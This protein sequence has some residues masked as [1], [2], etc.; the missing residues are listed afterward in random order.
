MLKDLLEFKNKI[1]APVPAHPFS[2]NVR[3][4]EVKRVNPSSI[5]MSYSYVK[6]Y[7]IPLNKIPNLYGINENITPVTPEPQPDPIKF[8]PLTLYDIKP[9]KGFMTQVSESY[10]KKPFIERMANQMQLDAGGGTNSLAVVSSIAGGKDLQTILNGMNKSK[11]PATTTTSTIGAPINTAPKSELTPQITPTPTPAPH[12]TPETKSPSSTITMSSV[13]DAFGNVLSTTGEAFRSAKA[14]LSEAFN[15][16]T[17][18]KTNEE[19]NQ[20]EEVIDIV[21]VFNSDDEINAFNEYQEITGKMIYITQFRNEVEA[22][23]EKQDNPNWWRGKRILKL[24]IENAKA[25]IANQNQPLITETFQP[26]TSTVKAKANEIN[27]KVETNKK[28]S[29]GSAVSSNHNQNIENVGGSRSSMKIEHTKPIPVP[30]N[31]STGEIPEPEKRKPGRPKSI[32][33]TVTP[34]QAPE[35]PPEKPP[36]GRAKSVKNPETSTKAPEKTRPKSDKTIVFSGGS[37]K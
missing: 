17:N 11:T 25:D 33:I 13:R 35:T 27:K 14:N 22:L 5:P 37:K 31:S 7:Q 8:G 1:P 32:K 30:V 10:N 4:I 15:N 34:T 36:R 19:T 9:K 28:N 29:A 16:A 12:P 23:L 18:K 2:F 21:R 3:K 20:P 24:F 6:P 26:E